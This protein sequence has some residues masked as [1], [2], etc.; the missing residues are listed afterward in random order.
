MKS[1]IIYSWKQC[2]EEI[3]CSCL[4]SSGA[5]RLGTVVQWRAVRSRP[6]EAQPLS[7]SL[8]LL[9][10]HF[11]KTSP[12]LPPFD[13]CL[14]WWFREPSPF[15]Q[16]PCC[17][18][19]YPW[20]EWRK[21]CLLPSQQLLTQ[22]P[23]LFFIGSHLPI[24]FYQLKTSHDCSLTNW[25]SSACSLTRDCWHSHPACQADKKQMVAAYGS[26]PGKVWIPDSLWGD[27]RGGIQFC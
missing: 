8:S 18:H 15:V 19:G 16:T 20:P 3:V 27:V 21:L 24:P 12:L 22:V 5:M 13:S 7:L 26:A 9:E 23:C 6:R 25:G 10:I 1:F 2:G 4:F 11:F 17:L 14:P